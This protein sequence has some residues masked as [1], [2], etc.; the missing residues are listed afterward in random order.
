MVYVVIMQGKVR[1]CMSLHQQ[2][3]LVMLLTDMQT[4]QCPTH[5]I[6]VATEDSS[7]RIYA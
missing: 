7:S 5:S 6:D 1:S 3:W 4:E 2:T